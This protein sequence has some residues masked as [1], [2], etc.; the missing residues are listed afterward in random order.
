[1]QT[2]LLYFVSLNEESNT[3]QHRRIGRVHLDCPTPLDPNFQL[4]AQLAHLKTSPA[5]KLK[6]P[7]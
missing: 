3:I 5:A 7:S 6:Y 2:R 1:V 4:A